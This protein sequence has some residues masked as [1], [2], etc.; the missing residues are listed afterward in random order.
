MDTRIPPLEI[1]IYYSIHYTYYYSIKYY[2]IY[3]YIYNIIEF[4]VD[5][6]IPPLETHMHI[7][8]NLQG[9]NSHVH[10]EFHGSFE[11]MSCAI[12]THAHA[13]ASL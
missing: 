8:A 7:H 6:R 10:R 4:P 2:I 13:Q 1:I 3:I 12:Y 9:W 11:S 5:M